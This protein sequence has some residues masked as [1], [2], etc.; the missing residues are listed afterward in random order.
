MHAVEQARRQTCLGL[1]DTVGDKAVAK[2]TLAAGKGAQGVAVFDVA[3][4][5][6]GCPGCT[7]EVT[8]LLMMDGATCIT[9]SS[10]RLVIPYH[11]PDGRFHSWRARAHKVVT[12]L[13]GQPNDG[14]G[15]ASGGGFC[16]GWSQAGYLQGLPGLLLLGARAKAQVPRHGR[17]M[18]VPAHMHMHACYWGLDLHHRTMYMRV[19]HL[20]VRKRFCFQ[21]T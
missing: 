18:Q 5:A 15:F 1:F 4:K 2:I 20:V 12:I 6:K 14:L 13:G 21:V 10:M 11:C 8:G 3:G 19:H 16:A 17:G 7:L 9:T